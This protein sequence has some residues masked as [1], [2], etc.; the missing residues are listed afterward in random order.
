MK[1][2]SLI[3]AGSLII[4]IALA[5]C[6]SKPTSTTTSTPD[7]VSNKVQQASSETTDQNI[8]VTQPANKSANTNTLNFEI[9][10][11]TY[12]NQNVKINYPQITNYSDADKQ[13]QIN[14]LIKNDI[15]NDYQKDIASLVKNYY[16]NNEEAEAALTENMNYEIKL[17]STKLLSILYVKNNSIPGSAHPSNSVHSININIEN[18]TVLKLKDLINIDNNFAKKFKNVNDKMWTLKALPGIEATDELNK[19]LVGVVSDELGMLNN[20]DLIDQLNSDDY[21]FYFTK[22]NFGMTIYVPHAAGDYA[23]LEVKYSDIK[24]NIKQENQVWKEFLK[25]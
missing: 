20:K 24:D 21:S 3:L 18:G 11:A 12:T 22:D 7:V 8:E 10:I 13:K 17:N 6:G 25:I 15:L 1:K 5:G 4:S 14:D 19:E 23:E 9:V 16:K 2:V